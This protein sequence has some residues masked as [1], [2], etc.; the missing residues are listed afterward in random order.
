[1]PSHNN[2]VP[3]WIAPFLSILFIFLTPAQSAELEPVLQ[4][5]SPGWQSLKAEKYTFINRGDFIDIYDNKSRVLFRSIQV[6]MDEGA[7]K[8]TAH[9][10]AVSGDEKYVQA[11]IWV[12]YIGDLLTTYETSTG[13]KVHDAKPITAQESG[14]SAE[15]FNREP[16]L[17]PPGVEAKSIS[18]FV[19]APEFFLS[20][21]SFLA[22]EESNGGSLR[23]VDVSILQCDRQT[24][25]PNAKATLSQAPSRSVDPRSENSQ[26][27]RSFPAA[28]ILPLAKQGSVKGKLDLET[29]EADFMDVLCAVTGNGVPTTV[30]STAY[31][32]SQV[33]VKDLVIRD[34]D[35]MCALTWDVYPG[36]PSL[37][38]GI[39][40]RS[41][42]SGALHFRDELAW[43]DC[44]SFSKETDIL[45]LVGRFGHE[46]GPL[47][48]VDG[49]AL[50]K[51]RMG[52]A[53]TELIW[54]RP[55]DQMNDLSIDPDETRI[56]AVGEDGRLHIFDTS[57]GKQLASIAGYEEGGL[58]VSNPEH[59]FMAS[60]G[61]SEAIALR[62]GYRAFPIEQ[63]DLHFNRPH[64]LLEQLSASA[65]E[66]ETARVSF[67]DRLALHE[68]TETNFSGFDH[69]PE[70]KAE[71]ESREGSK[72]K[73]AVKAQSSSSELKSLSAWVN[74]VPLYGRGGGSLSGQTV[75]GQLEIPL[76][77]GR[78]KIQ[79]SVMDQSGRESIKETVI[80]SAGNEAPP[81]V[82]RILAIGVSDYP[83]AEF[84]LDYAAK[85]ARDLISALQVE[86]GEQMEV[87]TK[88]LV[89]TDATKQGIQ[90]AKSFFEEGSP[91]DL[92]IV[93]LAG[94]GVLNPGDNRY[95]FCPADIDFDDFARNGVSYEE[96][97]SLL[98]RVP[99]MRRVILIDSCHSGELTETE[100]RSLQETA[101][102]RVENEGG[103]V[104][105]LRVIGARSTGGST[106][107]DEMR[108]SN[109]SF[110]DF[111]RRVGAQVLSSAGPLELALE[112]N[113]YENGVF[114]FYLLSALRNRDADQNKD[115][116][117]TVSEL[118]TRAAEDV[119]QVTDGLQRPR[120]RHANTAYD[121]P[122]LGSPAPTTQ[123]SSPP[124]QNGGTTI[125]TTSKPMKSTPSP[126][127]ETLGRKF[128]ELSERVLIKE[129][130]EK[131]SLSQIRY[132]INELYASYG[133]PFENS[134]ATEIRKHFS[135]FPWFRPESG[136]KM[137]VIDTRM[138]A[139][140]K[141]NIE[142]LAEARKSKQ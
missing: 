6:S 3:G 11:S 80:Y 100:L 47:S 140:E 46:T 126:A 129:D 8:G 79:L 87:K 107:K 7:G 37:L 41:L 108:N 122:L 40:V 136:L 102:A 4:D 112:G 116:A 31:E 117:L 9:H 70:I 106:S 131:L 137:E 109:F 30:V 72:L 42:S 2:F 105:A 138:T 67:V 97:E 94:H 24:A 43:A 10:F 50:A 85:D 57:S 90:T 91:D 95:Y 76:V 14:G 17:L 19:R 111:R 133:Y 132:A 139:I 52:E 65:G 23:E 44:L 96:I 127:K 27:I 82:A 13:E 141:R 20:P 88:L 29:S 45:Y 38:N 81:S 32:R 73:L 59:F 49:R 18:R 71:V 53:G 123:E 101:S 48:R 61:A 16:T 51:I 56:Y 33:F 104:R 21:N 118:F 121:F 28:E 77:T 1:M 98:D 35:G 113:G 83:G 62:S 12:K 5:I 130:A 69:L 25:R 142:V 54:Q 89:D 86:L 60:G 99:A 74:N 93:F 68:I 66:I 22:Y 135:Q 134:K 92:A 78:N 26:S 103:R 64:L 114:T 110:Q 84:D 125:T 63:F 58:L 39:E 15:D 119:I 124:S 55:I 115:G 120:F 36:K 34:S 75:D 128:L